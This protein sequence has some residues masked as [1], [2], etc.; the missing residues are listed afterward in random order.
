[1][2]SLSLSAALAITVA[3]CGG[4]SSSTPET[5]PSPSTSAAAS[6][7]TAPDPCATTNCQI[8]IQVSDEIAAEFGRKSANYKVYQG[9]PRTLGVRDSTGFR[10]LSPA[11]ASRSNVVTI[12]STFKGRLATVAVFFG[13]EPRRYTVVDL[14]ANKSPTVDFGYQW[15]GNALGSFTT[16]V[17]TNNTTMNRLCS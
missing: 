13:T 4:G 17:Y 7:S 2:R 3:A 16:Q 15:N 14:G 9:C 10:A 5:S 8:V 6:A 12:P 1:M 11:A